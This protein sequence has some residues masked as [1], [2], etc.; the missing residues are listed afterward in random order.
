MQFSFELY[1]NSSIN[2][3]LRSFKYL[4]FNYSLKFL[5]L[6]ESLKF[7]YKSWI[8]NHVIRNH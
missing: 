7:K 5:S 6:D 1:Q 8:M 2:I 3:I 4:L